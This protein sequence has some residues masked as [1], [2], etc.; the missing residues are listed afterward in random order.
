MR[1]YEYLIYRSTA[2]VFDGQINK[3][4]FIRSLIFWKI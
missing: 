1:N 4:I 2:G 3:G